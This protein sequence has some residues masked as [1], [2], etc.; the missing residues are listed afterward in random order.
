MFRTATREGAL[1]KLVR[2]RNIE[3]AIYNESRILEKPIPPP[4]P[5]VTFE[6]VLIVE[7]ANGSNISDQSAAFDAL[8]LSTE[9]GEPSF[10]GVS[11]SSQIEISSIEKSNAL[12]SLADVLDK[13]DDS[14]SVQ[15]SIN[16][17]A[18]SNMPQNAQDASEENNTLSVSGVLESENEPTPQFEN[19]QKPD[20][21]PLY[22]IHAQNERDINS[23]LDKPVD[24]HCEILE[25][26]IEMI[27]YGTLQLKPFAATPDGLT[28]R[29]VPDEISGMMPFN[30]TVRYHLRLCLRPFRPILFQHLLALILS[31]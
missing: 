22:E 11:D 12:E 13:P 3:P 19:E 31:L 20:L 26:D 14:V 7:G 18:S 5:V 16:A 28:K 9:M 30:K 8:E 6:E 29:E 27:Y 17:A 2:L 15:T 24:F 21:A 23:L 4:I 1:E 25:D 10:A